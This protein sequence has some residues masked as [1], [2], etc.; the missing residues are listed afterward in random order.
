MRKAFLLACAFLVS[1][2]LLFLPSTGARVIPPGRKPTPRCN[3]RV[4]RCQLP[5]PQ[6]RCNPY[7]RGRRCHLLTPPP[8]PPPPPPPRCNPYVRQ[9]HRPPPPPGC[10]PFVRHCHPPAI[11]GGP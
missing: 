1:F 3:P 4:R 8:P 10:G 11:P 7:V 5:L 2:A 6:P 9:C